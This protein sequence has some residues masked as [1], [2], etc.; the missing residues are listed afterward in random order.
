[1]EAT[2]STDSLMESELVAGLRHGDTAGIAT[3][4]DCYG[5]GLMRYLLS[6]L[7]RR[8]RA[9]DVFQDTWVRVME[10]A[11]RFNPGAPFEPWLFRIA[12][13]RAYDLLRREKRW[14][15]RGIG[16]AGQEEAAM[17]NIPDPANFMDGFVRQEM[18]QRLFRLLEPVHREILWLRFQRG[19]SYAEMVKICRLPLGTVKSRLNR[20]LDKLAAA[21]T[22][23]EETDHAQQQ[24]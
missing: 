14:W 1:M 24:R 23:M 9:E 3:L 15:R 8:D 2:R 21:Y 20:S 19:L 10:K 18:F 22:R 16:N 7:G 12:R 13:N 11:H 6:I 5:E 17:A 4:M